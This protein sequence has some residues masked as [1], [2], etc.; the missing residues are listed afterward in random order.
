MR[1]PRGANCE[2]LTHSDGKQAGDPKQAAAAIVKAVESPNPPLKLLLGV[3]ALKLARRKLDSM[4]NDIDTWE[5][6]TTSAD[7][8]PIAE[9]AAIYKPKGVRLKRS[10]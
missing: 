4:R 2:R 8:P 3:Y 9:S 10:D 7:F 1:R 5:A 6:T